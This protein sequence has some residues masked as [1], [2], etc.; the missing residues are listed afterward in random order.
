MIR[1]ASGAA[2]WNARKGRS[3]SWITK[4]RR[5]AIYLRDGFRCAYCG[6]DLSQVAPRGLGLDHLTPRVRAALRCSDLCD[7]RWRKV[8]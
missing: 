7:V 1:S 8:A 6:A 3:S 4:V 5:L 2:A